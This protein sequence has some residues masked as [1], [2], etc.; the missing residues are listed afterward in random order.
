MQAHRWERAAGYEVRVSKG[1]ETPR[2]L[3]FAAP[4]GEKVRDF[5]QA[6]QK[7]QDI[8]KMLFGGFKRCLYPVQKFS[9]DPD[10]NSPCCW[11]RSR[12]RCK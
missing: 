7:K 1:F 5:K 10:A 6:V 12:N 8:P 4:Q 3:A 11:S 2:E 9:S